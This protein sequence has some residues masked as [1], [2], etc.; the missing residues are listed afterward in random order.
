MH[1][2]I[3]GG[4]LVLGKKPDDN[5]DGKN[6]ILRAFTEEFPQSEKYGMSNAE[7]IEKVKSRNTNDLC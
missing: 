5:K 7:L 2:V 1:I 4:Q 3:V 6:A